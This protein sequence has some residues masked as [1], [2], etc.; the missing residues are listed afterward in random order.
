VPDKATVCGL[1]AALSVMVS[2][3]DLAPDAAGVKVMLIVQDLL[4]PSV[5]P[6]VVADC[7]KSAGSVPLIAVEDIVTTAPVLLLRV[8]F[9]VAAVS[10]INKLP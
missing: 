5:L 9:L 3:A 8:T 1:F 4:N 6:Q 2:M 7:A 10:L